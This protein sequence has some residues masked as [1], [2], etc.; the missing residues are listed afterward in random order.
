MLAGPASRPPRGAW[1]RPR[2]AIAGAAPPSFCF[3][4]AGVAAVSNQVKLDL[5][6]DA[7][8]DIGAMEV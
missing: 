5:F 6:Y 4:Q 7:Q 2:A 3:E 8:L 1:N